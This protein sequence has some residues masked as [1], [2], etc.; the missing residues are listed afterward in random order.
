MSKY[1]TDMVQDITRRSIENF[2]HGQ[3]HEDYD[4]LRR[5]IGEDDTPVVMLQHAT[6]ITGFAGSMFNYLASFE[7]ELP[8][9]ILRG[10][11]LAITE[12]AAQ[13]FYAEKAAQKK[14]AT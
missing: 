2:I 3:M 8:E 4:L 5:M 14:E 7:D 1:K 11:L 9:E 6:L 12:A 13:S 10:L